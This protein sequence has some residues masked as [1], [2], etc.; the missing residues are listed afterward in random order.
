MT[1]LQPYIASLTLSVPPPSGERNVL[2]KLAAKGIERKRQKQVKKQR[3]KADN[4]GYNSSDSSRSSSS[5]SDSDSDNDKAQRKVARRVRKINRKAKKDLRKHPANAV[6]IE[7][8]R[9]KRVHQIENKPL[10]DADKGNKKKNRTLSRD[11]EKLKRLE[12]VVIEDL[13]GQHGTS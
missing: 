11:L 5:S 6:E 10:R 7:E 1:A 4:N 13:V 2:D 3:N 12:F 9:A 8:D